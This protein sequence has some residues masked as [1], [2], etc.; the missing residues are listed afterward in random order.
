MGKDG[1][2]I[3]LHEKMVDIQTNLKV[4]K[5]QINKFG[6]YKYRSSEDILEEVKPLLKKHDLTL[7]VD[8][9]LIEISDL[10]CIRT[11]V[12]IT[13]R[14]DEK[15]SAVAYVGV[16]PN[17]KGMDIGQSFGASSSYA[18]KYAL[19]NLFLLDD[20]KDLDAIDNK[21]TQSKPSPKKQ[22]K[23]SAPKSITESQIKRLR[24]L[25]KDEKVSDKTVKHIAAG[26]KGD[27]FTKESAAQQIIMLEKV[28]RDEK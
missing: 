3:V 13:D 1:K 2:I 10:V 15:M 28:I 11:T 25:C 14:A 26:V 6:N 12:T 23:K 5:G 24:E 20:T 4:P 19:G 9:E 22:Y 17:R 18:K 7:K 8:E 16:D 21:A 27:K